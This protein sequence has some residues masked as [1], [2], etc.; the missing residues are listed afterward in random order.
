MACKDCVH[1][2]EALE[3]FAIGRD[4]IVFKCPATRRQS[5][6]QWEFPCIH[7]SVVQ[8]GGDPAGKYALTNETSGFC[9][10][11]I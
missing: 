2:S 1:F 10:V 4:L 3:K 11:F 8:L 6:A 9:P 7:C 5:L